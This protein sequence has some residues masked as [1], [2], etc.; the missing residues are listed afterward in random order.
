MEELQREVNG[1]ASELPRKEFLEKVERDFGFV[2]SVGGDYLVSINE[3]SI[4]FGT[5]LKSP[6]PLITT[7]RREARI[8]P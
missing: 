6:L 3:Y 2:L 1:L 4:Y 5:V 8:H 7:K